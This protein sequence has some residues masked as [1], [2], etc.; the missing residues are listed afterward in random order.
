MG[1]GHTPE[2]NLIKYLDTAARCR[3]LIG[4]YQ[5]HL[6][7]YKFFSI[8]AFRLSN[9]ILVRD[10]QDFKMYKKCFSRLEVSWMVLVAVY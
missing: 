10:D 2:A 6:R 5:F 3:K 4:F 9:Y 1:G 7:F 8:L